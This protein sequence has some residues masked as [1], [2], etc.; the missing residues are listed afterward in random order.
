M[1]E[2]AIGVCLLVGFDPRVAAAAASML[3][4]GVS[5][6]VGINLRRGRAIPCACFGT[7]STSPITI[8][9]VVRNA[10]LLLLALVIV[11]TPSDLIDSSQRGAYIVSLVC[12]ALG[13][14]LA[15]AVRR[16][17]YAQ[18]RLDLIMSGKESR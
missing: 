9:T 6:G 13:V 8:V 12:F 3:L 17:R 14:W 7:A 2:V 4:V 11:I 5:L 18:R 10:V 15:H 1:L 16:Y